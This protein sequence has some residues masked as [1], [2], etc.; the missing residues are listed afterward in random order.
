[1]IERVARLAQDSKLNCQVINKDY[2]VAD[3]IEEY[4]QKLLKDVE[5]IKNTN[6][7]NNIGYPIS[8]LHK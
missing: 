4:N 6:I 2:V 7:S 8:I 5:R 3:N 1:M